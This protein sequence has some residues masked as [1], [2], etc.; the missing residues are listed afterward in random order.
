MKNFLKKLGA[1]LTVFMTVLTI[2]AIPIALADP[3][4]APAQTSTSNPEQ[5][6]KDLLPAWYFDEK[7]TDESK[8]NVLKNVAD[9]TE[10]SW[11]QILSNITKF[12][13][14]ITGALTLIA[15]TAAGIMLV[16]ARGAE[17]QIKKG[18]EIIYL[19]ILGLAI[20]AASYAIILGIS[21]LKF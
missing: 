5:S 6:A 11:S 17:E 18:K 12:V 9:R 19:S 13:L 4:A 14:A 2:T 10:G 1:S 8:L 21:N 20:I 15:F 16:T 7:K 3:A